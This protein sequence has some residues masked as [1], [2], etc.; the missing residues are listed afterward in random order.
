MTRRG[1]LLALVGT[2]GAVVG[3]AFAQRAAV[4]KPQDKTALAEANVKELLLLMDTDK[5]GK[6]S[7]QQWMKF[8]EAEFDR[9]DT[10]KKGEL[11]P[12]QLMQSRVWVD[13]QAFQSL[14]K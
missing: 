10:D 4:P 1:V 5:T 12:K 14:G 3:A 8:M 9:L 2:A 6:I 7:K 13:H 11:D